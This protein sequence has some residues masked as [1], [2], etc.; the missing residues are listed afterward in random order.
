MSGTIEN[1]N[2]NIILKFKYIIYLLNIICDYRY[3]KPRFESFLK[4]YINIPNKNDILYEYANN[5]Y[6]RKNYSETIKNII[7]LVLD[8][9]Y[10]Y[11]LGTTNILP[12]YFNIKCQN[13]KTVLEINTKK[14]AFE[15]YHNFIT[16][17]NFISKINRM[18]ID[19][20]K[21]TKTKKIEND[22]LKIIDH[23]IYLFNNYTVQNN[24]KEIEYNI[25]E[26]KNNMT[27][28]SYLSAMVCENAE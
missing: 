3:D 24:T 5:I 13:V 7:N 4:T 8:L 27:I 17:E 22:V 9:K 25:C 10:E 2:N 14:K 11:E 23:V 1:T 28:D 12:S 21:Y 26:C 6:V 16:N 19:I 15:T 20:I 18:I